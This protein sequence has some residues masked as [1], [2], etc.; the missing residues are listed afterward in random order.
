LPRLDIVLIDRRTPSHILDWYFAAAA[1][2]PG[3][4]L[5]IDDVQIATRPMLADYLAGRTVLVT[6]PAKLRWRIVT[7]RAA[8]SSSIRSIRF[9]AGTVSVQTDPAQSR[10]GTMR[11]AP[12]GVSTAEGSGEYGVGRL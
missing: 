10:C 7:K 9:A 12:T 2:K 3:G 5:I 1:L 8:I 4:L 11:V 6:R